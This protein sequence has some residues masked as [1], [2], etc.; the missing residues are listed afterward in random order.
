MDLVKENELRKL[1]SE[2]EIRTRRAQQILGEGYNPNAEPLFTPE[3]VETF[4]VALQ[5]RGE[6]GCLDK[7]LQIPNLEQKTLEFCTS[8]LQ[9]SRK[10]GKLTEKQQEALSKIWWHNMVKGKR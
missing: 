4:Q 6:D 10:Y 3:H 7:I 5:N 1:L 9:A 8:L 2:I